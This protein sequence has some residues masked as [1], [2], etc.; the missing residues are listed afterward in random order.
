MDFYKEKEH[1]KVET[2]YR[3]EEEKGESDF[4]LNID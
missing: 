3:E 1:H 4:L 2:C